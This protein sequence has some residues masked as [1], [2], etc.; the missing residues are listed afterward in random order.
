MG[1]SI[2][3][4]GELNSAILAKLESLAR[5]HQNE[6]NIYFSTTAVF[7]CP[8][9][10]ARIRFDGLAP[11]LRCLADEGLVDSVVVLGDVKRNRA[12]RPRS[13]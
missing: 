5:D 1:S 12:Y 6:G 8:E 4:P 3:Q 13:I 2:R 10:K 11:Y 7:E 9:V